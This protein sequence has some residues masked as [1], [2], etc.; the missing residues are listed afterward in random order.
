[1]RKLTKRIAFMFLGV[2]LVLM[3]IFTIAWF[4]ARPSVPTPAK[5]AFNTIYD[6]AREK[7]A[8]TEFFELTGRWPTSTWELVS[9]S[10]G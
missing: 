5:I 6:L 1:M 9:N 8:I 3:F 2:V 10:F 4:E 7:G